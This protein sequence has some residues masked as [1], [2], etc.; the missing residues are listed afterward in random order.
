MTQ[1][2]IL[3]SDLLQ[4]VLEYLS[5]KDLTHVRSYFHIKECTLVI[6]CREDVPSLRDPNLATVSNI[7]IIG[8]YEFEAAPRSVW[9]AI[10]RV[11]DVVRPHLK[12][13]TLK[14][15]PGS[16]FNLPSF[17]KGFPKLEHLHLLHIDSEK[18]LELLYKSCPSLQ[19]LTWISTYRGAHITNFLADFTTYTPELTNLQVKSKNDNIRVLYCSNKDLGSNTRQ[20]RVRKHVLD[21]LMQARMRIEPESKA[22]SMSIAS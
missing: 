7:I 10:R 8:S 17:E 16:H 3:P 12:H 20:R 22:T 1:S 6:T 21:H 14:N 13:L 9:K 2:R 15:A 19:S 11:F 18:P 5:F 4:R